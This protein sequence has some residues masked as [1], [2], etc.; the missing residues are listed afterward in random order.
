MPLVV[1]VAEPLP[2]PLL[3]LPADKRYFRVN[4]VAALTVPYSYRHFV[5]PSHAPAW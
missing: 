3:N 4:D 1:V 2:Y 5:R